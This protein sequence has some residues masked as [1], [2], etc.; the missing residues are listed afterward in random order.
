MNLGLWDGWVELREGTPVVSPAGAPVALVFDRLVAGSG[1]ADVAKEFAL[2]PH[3]LTAVLAYDALGDDRDGAGPP[4][5]QSSPRRP[6]LED[7]LS[8]G[9]LAELFPS[10]SRPARLA[11]SAGLLQIHDFWDSSHHAAQRADDL[12][13]RS[14]SAYWHGIAH[15]REPDPGNAGY[16]F[17]RVG[18]HPVFGPLASAVGPILQSTPNGSQLADRLAPRGAWDPYA[19]IDVCTN[20]RPG[21]DATAREIQR[22][23]MALLLKASIPNG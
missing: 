11:L 5:V 15:R 16:W 10:L 2:P 12:G 18:R 22:V 9:A 21:F 23:E 19:F 4:L 13:E 3:G 7:A 14:V 8:E 17:R 20:P 6:D 1:L